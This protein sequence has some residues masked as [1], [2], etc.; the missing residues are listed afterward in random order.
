[1][2]ER[3]PPRPS[4]DVIRV[5]NAADA[6]SFRRLRQHAL[7]ESPE[8]FS[9]DYEEQLGYPLSFYEARIRADSDCCVLGAFVNDELVGVL[10]VAREAGAKTRHKATLTSMYVYPEARG[11]GIAQR[12]LQRALDVA[13]AMPGVQRVNLGVTEG[14]T[15][16]V[17]LY[18]R[19][20]FET[21]GHE[22]DALR[23]NGKRL[24]E[25]LM[26]KALVARD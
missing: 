17:A 3:A 15:A 9:S 8:A 21:Y 10:A 6:A 13:A 2:P 5:L 16:A 22:P 12:L 20:G 19:F 7:R 26:T 18:R 23:V 25:W 24:G 4:E 14:N 11:H 1:M